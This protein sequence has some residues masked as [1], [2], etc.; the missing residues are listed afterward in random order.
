MS[1]VPQFLEAKY[2]FKLNDLVLN[3]L[4]SESSHLVG[5]NG[6][7]TLWLDVP[8][9]NQIPSA[10]YADGRYEQAGIGES[11]PSSRARHFFIHRL[12]LNTR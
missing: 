12:H 9:T 10:A 8:P 7:G 1:L 6:S 2:F 4:E 11:P 5:A 3:N